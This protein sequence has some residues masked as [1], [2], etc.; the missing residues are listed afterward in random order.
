RPESAALP[1]PERDGFRAEVDVPISMRDGVRLATDIYFPAEPGVYPVLL[2]RS[3]YG[4]H[5]SVMMNI[6][7]PQHLV[8]NGYVVAIQDT[9]GRFAS[10]GDWYPF[11]DE[12][13]GETRDGY[14]TVELSISEL[15][16][17]HMRASWTGFNSP[18]TWPSW[19][20][21]R[22]CSSRRSKARG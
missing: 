20:K 22:A 14:D 3:P 7:A 13:F 12:G 2:E 8:K 11:R 15:A 9:R 10:E 16:L 1:V 5:A 19:T 17:P 21:I 6:G 18:L 4:K